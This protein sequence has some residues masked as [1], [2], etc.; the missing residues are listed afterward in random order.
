[1]HAT[2]WWQT[3]REQWLEKRL[4]AGREITL[5]QR[6]IFIVPSKTALAL[7]MLIAVLFLLGINFQNSL[8]YAVCFWLLALL[9]VNIF[10]TYRNLSGLSIRAIGIEPCFVGEKAVLE[11]ELIAPARQKRLALHFAWPGEDE[12]AVNLVNTGS[13]RVKLSHTSSRRGHF[14]PPYVRVSTRYPTGLAVAWSYVT[15]DVRGLVYPK[16]VEKSIPLTGREQAE[17]QEDGLEIAG[18]SSDFG[19]IRN[20]QPGDSLRHIHWAK[21]AQTGQLHTKSFVD[22]VSHDRW[23]DWDS[24]PIPGIEMRLSYLCSKVLEFHQAQQQYGL[25]IPGTLI[26]PDKGEAHK[27]RCLRALALYGIGDE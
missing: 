15:L 2:E 11:M 8:V 10:H 3:H 16:P 4:P 17:Q 5:S 6:R 21:Y 18:G 19:G 24:L 26:Q 14:R 20:Y 22:Y 7:L 25:K 9:V 1:M 12:T 13:L 27:A 23:L